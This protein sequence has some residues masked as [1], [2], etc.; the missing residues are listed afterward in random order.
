MTGPLEIVRQN[1]DASEQIMSGWL[2]AEASVRPHP[3]EL[4]R[5]RFVF[6]GR[7][8]SA[9]MLHFSFLSGLAMGGCLALLVCGR[10]GSRHR[11]IGHGDRGEPVRVPTE[12]VPCLD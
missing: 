1:H 3:R 10:F 9:R 11:H 7:R 5:S 4:A 2:G 6:W 12:V 8:L